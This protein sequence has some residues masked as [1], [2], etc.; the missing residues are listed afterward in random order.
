MEATPDDRGHR[1]QRS[2]G[3]LDWLHGEI[4]A[5]LGRLDYR[6]TRGRRR[7]VTARAAAGRPVTLPEILE[8]DTGITQSSAYRNLE[9]LERSGAIRRIVMSGDHARFELAEP[10][11]AHHHHLICI[12]CGTIEDVEL[13]AELEQLLDTTLAATAADNHFTPLQHSLDLHGHCA[14]C[15]P[16]L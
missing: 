9:I 16:D 1:Q 3:P 13:D 7:L 15:R 8:A 5:L 11:V 4:G 6:Y 2:R 10:L 14:V 12:R